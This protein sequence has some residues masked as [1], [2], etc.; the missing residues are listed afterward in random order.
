MHP[1]NRWEQE[2]LN[3]LEKFFMQQQLTSIQDEIEQLHQIEAVEQLQ[4]ED[5]Q[6]RN[7]DQLIQL[8]QYEH[9]SFL[10]QQ[11]N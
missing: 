8:Q 3:E 5:E 9:I 11:L 10:H 4:E 6:Q 1:R 2:Q 7:R